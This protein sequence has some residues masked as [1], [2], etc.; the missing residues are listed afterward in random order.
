[1]QRNKRWSYRF[2]LQLLLLGVN[3]VEQARVTDQNNRQRNKV[4]EDHRVNAKVL[5]QV[6]VGEQDALFVIIVS[7]TVMVVE[8]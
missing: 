5:L 6:F 1:M 7:D 4:I 2:W 3:I 8:G